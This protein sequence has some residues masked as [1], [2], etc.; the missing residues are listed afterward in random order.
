MLFKASTNLIGDPK[1]QNNISFAQKTQFIASHNKSL[2]K[3]WP[4]KDLF[5]SKWRLKAITHRGPV[6]DVGNLSQIRIIHTSKWVIF[7]WRRQCVTCPREWFCIL[8][9]E[10]ND[11]K[12][13]TCLIIWFRWIVRSRHVGSEVAKHNLRSGDEVVQT[14]HVISCKHRRH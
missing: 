9:L 1:R 11:S 10:E 7:H 13:A 6:G 5:F 12:V 4:E 2:S 3:I 14:C 8:R